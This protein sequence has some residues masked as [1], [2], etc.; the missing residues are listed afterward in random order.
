MTSLSLLTFNLGLL[1]ALGGWFCPVPHVPE[2]LRA[3]ASALH[4]SGADVVLLQEIYRSEHRRALASHLRD[5]Y[6]YTSSP[7]EPAGLNFGSGLLILSRFPVES[8]FCLFRSTTLEEQWFV[9]KGLIDATV[10]VPGAGPVRVLNTHTT[11]GGVFRHPQAIATDSIRDAQI[12]ELCARLGGSIA[13]VLA[14][15]FNTGPGVSPSNYNALLSAGLIDTWAS[16]NHVEAPTWD[17]MNVLNRSGPHRH[18][19]PQRIDHV[20]LRAT[21]QAA[22]VRVTSSEVALLKPVVRLSN[23]QRVTLSDHYAVSTTLELPE[24]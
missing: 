21:D 16:L 3:Q 19:P 13:T 2:R 10:A 7:E 4:E 5:V 6:P 11:A 17:P 9:R 12:S 8:R 20:F 15:D 14:G 23:D 24:R 1:E 18:C 22:G